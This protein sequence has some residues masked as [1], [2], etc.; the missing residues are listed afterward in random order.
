MVLWSL[1]ADSSRVFTDNPP[2]VSLRIDPK[3]QSWKEEAYW[4]PLPDAQEFLGEFRIANS[5]YRLYMMKKAGV[6]GRYGLEICRVTDFTFLPVSAL[7][8]EKAS[9]WLLRK[10]VNK[11]GKLD[12]ADGGEV[13]KNADGTP[14][15]GDICTYLSHRDADGSFLC[16]SDANSWN[17]RWPIII[18]PDGVPVYRALN[19][20]II[21]ANTAKVINP[22]TWKPQGP[23]VFVRST[24]LVNGNIVG[25]INMPDSGANNGLMNSIGNS[26]IEV[27]RSG[28]IR[29]FLPLPQY[30]ALA[31]FGSTDGFN[32]VGMGMKPECFIYNKDGLGL[33]SFAIPASVHWE[34]FW[35]DYADAIRMYKGADGEIYAMIA[36]NVKGCGR[37]F[38]F[39]HKGLIKDSVQP[40]TLLPTRAAELAA[41]AAQPVR[42]TSARPASPVIRIPRLEKAMPI[43]GD[44]L[45]WRSITPQM[46]ITPETSSG[47]ISGPRD[48]SAV[49]R[50]AAHGQNL[51]LQVLRFDNVVSFHQTVE[52]AYQQDTVEISL[53]GF[54][55]GFKF[56]FSKT[57]DEGDIV[58][59]QRF[60]GIPAALM[61]AD[62]CP[63]LVKLF[64]SAAE[65]P[66]RELIESIY[67]EDLS[68]SQVVLYEAKLPIT[69]DGAYKGDEK[70]VF[71]LE[72][73]KSFWIGVMID[74][75]DDPGTD[76]QN[77][78][79]WPATYGTFNAK[80][81]GA[82]AVVE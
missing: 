18:D 28:Q 57:I 23:G 30:D 29:W 46:I 2:G 55:D 60:W 17:V 49:V 24:V 5:I 52:K 80:E 43:D 82:I 26:L 64:D 6:D 10:D 12:V 15:L 16:R 72:P 77:Y 13:M 73:G 79:L 59:R 39:V 50:I 11:D 44:L 32:M 70:A 14:F 71:S 9:G 69:K 33:G 61:P 75:N 1:F 76:Q 42:F 48:C 7:I 81:D 54:I 53:N 19:R 4:P 74:D 65:I 66:E 27:D 34:G 40:W 37:W 36:D 68:N 63:R 78:L 62:T 20:Q 31:G 45:K 41:Q 51:Y 47:S 8:F 58:Q 3:S 21:P 67:G 35:L 56:N 22:Y 25:N 38:H